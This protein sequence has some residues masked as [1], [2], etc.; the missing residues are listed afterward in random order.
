MGWLSVMV[1][2]DTQIRKTRER[3]NTVPNKPLA[4]FM[5]FFFRE[6]LDWAVANDLLATG[7]TR[8]A[9]ILDLLKVGEDFKFLM[10]KVHRGTCKYKA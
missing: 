2:K 1:S 9:K 8:K 5:V 3:S 7:Q 6:R 10:C 4:G